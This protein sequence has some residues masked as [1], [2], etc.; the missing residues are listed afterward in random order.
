MASRPGH[1]G[2]SRAAVTTSPMYGRHVAG[3]GWGKAGCAGAGRRGAGLR[4]RVGR[5]GGGSAQQRLSPFLFFEFLFPSKSLMKMLRPLQSFS[6]FGVK[7]RNVPHK[8][9]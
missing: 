6:G 8:I 2:R 4:A 3:V 5:K 9:L 7:I 1:A